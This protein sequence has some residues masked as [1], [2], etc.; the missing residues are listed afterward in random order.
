MIQGHVLH[1]RRRSRVSFPKTLS[2]LLTFF[3][4]L[5]CFFS[6]LNS[7]F[8]IKSKSSIFQTKFVWLLPGFQLF[9]ATLISFRLRFQLRPDKTPWQV[10]FFS[11]FLSA[12]SMADHSSPWPLYDNACSI[13]GIF[14]SFCNRPK[15]LNTRLPL[16]ASS[17]QGYC[18]KTIWNIKKFY[19]KSRLTT[20]LFFDIYLNLNWASLN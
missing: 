5:L 7:S 8:L 9:P 3:W 18:A 15:T 13:G 2:A 10:Q 16:P 14:G 11:I 17:K 1:S 6:V 20:Q 19:K 4:F 12:C